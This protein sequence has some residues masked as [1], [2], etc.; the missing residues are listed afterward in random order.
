ME[1]ALPS[2]SA[3]AA[4]RVSALRQRQGNPDLMLRLQV[5]GG[6][7][8]GFQYKFGFADA[9]SDDDVVVERDGVKLVVDQMSLPY[10]EGSVVDYVEDLA[11][12]SFQ[13]KN[14]NASSSCG[15]G[16]SFSV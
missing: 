12:A 13:V 1:T 16:A 6:G 7:C 4:R 10:L 15:C 11:G 8:S 3:N 9:V 5:D 14:P 2:L